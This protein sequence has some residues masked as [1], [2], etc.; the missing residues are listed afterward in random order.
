M[1]K[2]ETLDQKINTVL[3]W[4][5]RVAYLGSALFAI[6]LL[7]CLGAHCDPS[8]FFSGR[9]IVPLGDTALTFG[10]CCLLPRILQTAGKMAFMRM[11]EEDRS[12]FGVEEV[13]RCAECM[14]QYLENAK[15]AS[16]TKD[17]QKWCNAVLETASGVKEQIAL[18]PVDSLSEIEKNE[19]GAALKSMELMLEENESLY[20]STQVEPQSSTSHIPVTGS[21]VSPEVEQ[22][23]SLTVS[24][25]KEV[26]R[27]TLDDG[28]T[29]QPLLEQISFV[30][31]YVR[32]L[33]C[34]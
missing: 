7:G 22:S 18:L 30:G 21:I 32:Y 31:N 9:A 12:S 17:V 8:S 4:V 10:S 2:I 5:S 14:R 16:S 28:P 23:P 13:K 24:P 29:T 33:V 34:G 6:G 20:P 15:A 25:T 19:L 27:K 1:I 3:K 26:T 11:I